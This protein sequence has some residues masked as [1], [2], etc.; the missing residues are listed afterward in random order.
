[1]PLSTQKVSCVTPKPSFCLDW[2]HNSLFTAGS[3]HQVPRSRACRRRSASSSDRL[4][5]LCWSAVAPC[6]TV[7]TRASRAPASPRS[8]SWCTRAT[9]RTAPGV[10]HGSQGGWARR[11]G[12][13]HCAAMVYFAFYWLASGHPSALT[14]EVLSRIKPKP[15]W[16]LAPR[17]KLYR[18]RGGNQKPCIY[19]RPRLRFTLKAGSKVGAV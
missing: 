19:P 6:A 1:M 5:T 3:L 16:I 9:P 10:I 14:T 11:A 8:R 18:T 17:G 7:R 2:M 12:H 15:H 13:T 4:S